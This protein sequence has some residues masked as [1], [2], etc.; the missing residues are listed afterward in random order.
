MKETKMTRYSS[1]AL[2]FAVGCLAFACSDDDPAPAP[3]PLSFATDV[4][5][6]FV[7]KCEGCHSEGGSNFYPEHAAP[8]VDVAYAST[9]A[10]NVEGEFFYDRILERTSGESP[11]GIMP[12]GPPC[13]GALD[14]EGC[15]TTEEHE[16]IQ[17]WVD[18]GALP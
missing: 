3:E 17:K 14:A 2:I 11:R 1:S 6:I 13:E 18:E 9:V 16:L 5:P 12:P 7:E 4:Y 10:R 8:D 15:L